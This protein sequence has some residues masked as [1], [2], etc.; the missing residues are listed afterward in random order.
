MLLDN[1]IILFK[2]S[3]ACNG[4]NATCFVA[5]NGVNQSRMII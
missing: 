1:M 4:I 3:F 5:Q 2:E